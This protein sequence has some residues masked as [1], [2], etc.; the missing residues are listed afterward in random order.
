MR[1]G[2]DNDTALGFTLTELVLV[3]LVTAVIVAVATSAYQTYSIRAEV[4][5]GIGGSENLQAAIAQAYLTERS[6][7][8]GMRSLPE[9][10]GGW[11][12]VSHVVSGVDV[13]DG[14]IDLRYGGEADPAIAARSLSLTP[15]E[16][17]DL[18]IVWIC[19]NR[20]PGPG[21]KPLGFSAGGRQP[22]QAATTIEARY[23]PPSCR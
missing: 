8:R 13:V 15:Y 3:L 21:L 7:P 23:L 19:G 16:T 18:E 10:P 4:A 2:D 14:R 1:Q 9:H 20:I 22:V 5:A 6:T 11:G 12:S 17:A